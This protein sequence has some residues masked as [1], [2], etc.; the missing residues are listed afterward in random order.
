MWFLK[1]TEFNSETERAA[2]MCTFPNLF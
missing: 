1:S 2:L